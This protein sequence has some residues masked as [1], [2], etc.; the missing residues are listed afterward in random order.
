MVIKLFVT[1]LDFLTGNEAASVAQELNDELQRMCEESNGRLFGFATLPVKNP[2]E[3]VKEV[4][5]LK[6]L[7]H[8]RGVILGTPGAGDG[9]DHENMRDVLAAL[10]DQDQMIFLH[11]HYGIGNEQFHDTGHAL[12]LALGFPFETTVAVSRLITSGTLDKLPKLKLLVA[13]AGAT[14]PSLIGRLDSCVDHDAHLC[15]RLKQSPSDYMKQNMYF[16]AISYSTPGLKCLIETVGEDRIMFGT[17]N[18]FFPPLGVNDV[19]EALWP[20]TVNVYDNIDAMPAAMQSGLLRGNA[21]RL[22]KL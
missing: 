8:I 12:F 5:R 11:P 2:V 18:P 7:S 9:I 15:D 14:L 4:H 6:S 19:T 10:E 17:D 1:R 3:A 20:S 22:L 21:E 16:D 13:H